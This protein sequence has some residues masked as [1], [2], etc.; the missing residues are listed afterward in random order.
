MRGTGPVHPGELAVQ[1]R[2]G[3]SVTA[4]QTGGT[5]RYWRL[6]IESW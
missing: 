2:A 1:A 3:V 6:H 5:R 4:R